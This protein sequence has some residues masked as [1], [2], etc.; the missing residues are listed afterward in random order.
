VLYGSAPDYGAYEFDP[1]Q[2]AAITGTAQ[3]ATESEIEGKTI[4]V[5]LTGDTFD[6]DVCKED[7]A[8][9]TAFLAGFVGA[10]S[11]AGSWNDEVTL[12][13]GNCNVDSATAR[14]VTIPANTLDIEESE[15]VTVTICDT[16]T[17][18]LKEYIATPDI[19]IGYEAAGASSVSAAWVSGA[20][21]GNYNVNGLTVTAP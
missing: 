13:H 12:A 20:P 21:A 8:V 2:S 6:S 11:G 9:T 14:T 3:N 5:T 19:H 1:T 17:A 7:N 15:A 18:A 10:L 4:I 16:C